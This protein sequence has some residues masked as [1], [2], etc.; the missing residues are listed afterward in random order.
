MKKIN[1]LGEACPLPVIKAKKALVEH[2]AIEIAVDNE[3]ATQNLRKLAEQKGYQYGSNQLSDKEYVVQIS[4]TGDLP[5]VES[6]PQTT[7]QVADSYIVVIDTNVMGRG[8]DKLGATLIKGFIYALTEQDQ[9]P[10]R[11][12]LYN[13]GVHFAV[14]EADSLEDLT[15]LAKAGVE[16][17]SCGACTDFYG[18]TEK[19]AVG[20]ITN[21]YRIVEMMREASRIV[22]P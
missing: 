11:V 10:E 6:Q 14:T 21:M 2:E 17:Y 16:I 5:V 19:V 18:L 7:E 12:I 9:L 4:R 20:E 3:I 15:T 1:A 8:D 22:K 13:G